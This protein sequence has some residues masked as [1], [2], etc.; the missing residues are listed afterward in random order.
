MLYALHVLNQD[1]VVQESG[2]YYIYTYYNKLK[3]VL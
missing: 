2:S 1:H 3:Q